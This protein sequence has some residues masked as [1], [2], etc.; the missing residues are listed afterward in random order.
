MKFCLAERSHYTRFV[1]VD[2]NN[3]NLNA[4]ERQ[5]LELVK[6]GKSNAQIARE[7]YLSESTVKQHLR[8]AY[9]KLDFPRKK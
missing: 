5:I 2:L 8:L 1:M 4:R 9:K 6:A 3:K 7:L